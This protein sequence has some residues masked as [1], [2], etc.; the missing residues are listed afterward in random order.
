M[1]IKQ[2]SNGKHKNYWLK[3][4]E[5]YG[6]NLPIINFSIIIT[7]SF[8]LFLCLYIFVAAELNKLCM[9]VFG[10]VLFIH[11]RFVQKIAENELYPREIFRYFYDNWFFLT[12]T[13]VFL[14][15][16]PM[17][18]VILDFFS[19]LQ[20]FTPAI[21]ILLA[22]FA[23]LLSMV[24]VSSISLLFQPRLGAHKK[25]RLYFKVVVNNMEQAINKNEKER[26]KLTLDYFKYLK[27]GLKAF[28]RYLFK[29]HGFEIA[30]IDSYYY[31]AYQMFLIRNKEEL[32]RTS[33]HLKEAFNAIGEREKEEN[34]RK[35]LTAVYTLQKENEKAT[36]STAKLQQMIKP[37]SRMDKIKSKIASPYTLPL[38]TT[39]VSLI[40]MVLNAVEIITE[41][42]Q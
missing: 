11:H 20:V 2:I 25:A 6:K 34:L 29:T 8:I 15:V 41:F 39:V 32:E 3:M 7:F 22:L 35:F 23:F 26:K 9:V 12:R 36:L 40:L 42:L 33:K 37:V 18:L 21:G 5:W 17:A 1:N 38:I 4:Y 14:I 27:H 31:K 13:I 30:D 10:I 19:V 24:L 16:T 28:N